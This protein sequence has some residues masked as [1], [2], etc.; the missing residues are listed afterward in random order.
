VLQIVLSVEGGLCLELVGSRPIE[1]CTR[2]NDVTS[3]T[4]YFPCP[5][6]DVGYD[7]YCILCGIARIVQHDWFNVVQPEGLLVHTL[8]RSHSGAAAGVSSATLVIG[9][10]TLFLLY[11]SHR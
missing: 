5:A 8:H 9:L 11:T 7:S 1:S 3:S 6:V 10:H 2:L 4:S